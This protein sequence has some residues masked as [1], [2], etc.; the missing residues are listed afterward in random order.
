MFHVVSQ[1]NL[2]SFHAENI[3]IG[4]FYPFTFSPYLLIVLY[5]EIYLYKIYRIL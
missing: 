4:K 3:Q 2:R 1:K 5:G